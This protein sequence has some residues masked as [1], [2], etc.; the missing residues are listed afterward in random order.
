MHTEIGYW[1]IANREQLG[2]RHVRR[3]LPLAC[4]SPRIIEAIA[5]GKAP[6]NLTVSALT[7]DLPHDW[8]SQERRFLGV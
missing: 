7:A 8:G 2:E 5:M 4:L 6:S 1:T 3:I